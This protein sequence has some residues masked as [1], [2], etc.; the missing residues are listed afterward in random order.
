MF[1]RSASCSKVTNQRHAGSEGYNEQLYSDFHA[2]DSLIMSNSSVR[3]GKRKDYISWQKFFM[4]VAHLAKLRSKDPETQ[5]GWDNNIYIHSK[6]YN[7][8]L[9][10]QV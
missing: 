3:N 10:T 6:S 4:S 2:S 8:L 5:V 7:N 1:R 9:A